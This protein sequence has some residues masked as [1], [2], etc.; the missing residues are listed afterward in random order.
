MERLR[1]IFV[2]FMHIFALLATLVVAL[3]SAQT[4]L[5]MFVA[6][7]EAM[8]EIAAK[9]RLFAALTNLDNDLQR[10]IEKAEQGKAKVNQI[11]E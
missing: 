1:I 3:F 11:G 7:A 8:C 6:Y 4:A 2:C 5:R 9:R 10:A